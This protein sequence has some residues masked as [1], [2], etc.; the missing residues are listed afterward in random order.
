MSVL[1]AQVI[2]TKGEKTAAGAGNC[3]EAAGGVQQDVAAG[4]RSG[5]RKNPAAEQLAAAAQMTRT[6]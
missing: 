5:G 6:P 4:W 3:R 2:L 1:P